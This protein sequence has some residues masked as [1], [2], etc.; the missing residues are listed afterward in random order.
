MEE[1]FQLEKKSMSGVGCSSAK[2]KP[3]K[4]WCKVAWGVETQQGAS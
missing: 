1:A 4:A 2:R 3:R